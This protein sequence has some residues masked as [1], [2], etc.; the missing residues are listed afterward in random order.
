MISDYYKTLGIN[1]NTN[2]SEIKQAYRQKAKEF[3]PDIN[4]LPDAHEK[5]IE[6]NEAYE[7]L[8]NFKTKISHISSPN[9]NQKDSRTKQDFYNEWIKKE[10][11]KARAK[12][13]YQAKMKFEDFKKTRIYKTTSLLS[14]MV[15]IFCLL[16]GFLIIIGC[17]YGLYFQ[18]AIDS[19]TVQGIVA[20]LFL[21]IIGLIFILYSWINLKKNQL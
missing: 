4:K 16:T 7:F 18:A 17:A 9:K 14:S 15:D 12:A 6:I 21:T 13:A 19:I 1:Q 8:T 10:R 11:D 3:H 2:L 5:F 20:A